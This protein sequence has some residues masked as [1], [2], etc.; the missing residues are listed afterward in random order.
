MLHNPTGHSLSLAERLIDTK[1]LGT[2]TT[3]GLQE[4]AVAWCLDQGLLR[5]HAD[6]VV[7]RLATARL[8]R[9]RGARRRLPLRNSRAG[10]RVRLVDERRHGQVAFGQCLALARLPFAPMFQVRASPADGAPGKSDLRE[11]RFSAIS[12]CITPHESASER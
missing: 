10:Q 7:Q 9:V 6:R 12:R 3:P 8:R 1:R 2:L 5:R 4:R 11:I